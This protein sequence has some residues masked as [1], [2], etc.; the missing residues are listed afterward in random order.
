LPNVILEAAYLRVPIVATAVG[1][2]AEVVSHKESG[3]LIQPTLAQLT[4]GIAQFLERPQDFVRMAERAHQGI[5]QN[6]SF[7]VRTEKL[8]QVYERVLGRRP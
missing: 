3:W 5:L 7:D 8:T 1:G 4:D 6:Y 2:T